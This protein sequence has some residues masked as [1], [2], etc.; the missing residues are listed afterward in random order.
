MENMSKELIKAHEADRA[1]RKTKKAEKAKKSKPA[2]E[3]T[4]TAIEIEDETWK[5]YQFKQKYI[6]FQQVLK[7]AKR[8]TADMKMLELPSA[9]KMLFYFKLR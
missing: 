3:T 1:N 7:A 8:C 5:F 2:E 6:F 4:S 9:W